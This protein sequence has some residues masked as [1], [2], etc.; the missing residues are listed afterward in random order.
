MAGNTQETGARL[1]GR[2]RGA[3]WAMAALALL[4][5]LAAGWPW[6][7][8]DYVFA[9]VLMFGSLG[10]YELAARLT[11]NTAY[12]T[13]AALAIAATFLLVW[14]NAAVGI[15]DSEADGLLLLLVPAVGFIGALVARF[16]PRGMAVVMFTAALTVV[17]IAVIAL[18]AGIVPAFNSVF[19]ILGIAGVFGMMFIGSGLLFHQAARQRASVDVEASA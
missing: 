2:R 13:G 5:P 16:Q 1:E 9:A 17:S 12:R 14:V 7:M 6:T 8:G 10:L 4:V 19:E 11:G 18:I 3:L 15:T